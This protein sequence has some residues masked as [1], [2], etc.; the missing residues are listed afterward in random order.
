[1]LRTSW[2][3]SWFITI[4]IFGR[5]LV[6]GGVGLQEGHDA[7]RNFETDLDSSMK[8]LLS[9]DN[10]NNDNPADFVLLQHIA[11]GHLIMARRMLSFGDNSLLVPAESVLKLSVS[12]FER[13]HVAH[14]NI[15]S[16]L[17]KLLG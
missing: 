10:N 11:H 7:L 6:L 13:A 4:A 15:T 2:T 1:M 16:L 14:L 8:W 17:A 3:L 12:Y 5:F 9:H